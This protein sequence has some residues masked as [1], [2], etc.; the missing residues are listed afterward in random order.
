MSAP[1]TLDA[2]HPLGWTLLLAVCQTTLLALG[3]RAWLVSS[4]RPSGR[5]HAVGYTA[6]LASLVLAAGTYAGLKLAP[7]LS[8]ADQLSSVLHRVAGPPQLLLAGG[9]AVREPISGGGGSPAPG[10]RFDAPAA[11][12]RVARR[13]SAPMDPLAALRGAAALALP[14][15][16]SAW[17]LG[18]V[19]LLLRLA[20]GVWSVRRLR[21]RARPLPVDHAPSAGQLSERLGLVG[22]EWLESAEIDAPAAVGWRRPA[23]MLPAGL[24]ESMAPELLEPLLAHE[25]AHVRRH[26]ARKALLQGVADALLFFC[27]GA[28]WLS[29]QV[30][31]AREE[32]CDDAAVA[33]CG[34][35]ERCARAL[36]ALVGVQRSVPIL[37]A[38]G[39][40]APSLA[41]RI[42]RLLKGEDEMPRRTFVQATS[43]VVGVVASAAAVLVVGATALAA[44]PSAPAAPAPGVPRVPS[45]YSR[46]PGAPLAI[47]R[48][49]P[50]DGFVFRTVRVRNVS[51][52]RISAVRFVAVME[53]RT[54]AAHR[55]A[56]S[57]RTRLP[58]TWRP[59]RPRNCSP[60]C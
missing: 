38:I 10:G 35:R 50:G 17:A 7:G 6:L 14:V 47:T 3:V 19:F 2:L 15:A 22:V 8:F 44:R 59:E 54:S 29:A 18:A 20:G 43:V 1:V 23:V 28:R 58:R 32:N 5:R 27:P 57:K 12:E 42:R 55:C 60:R 30:R 52:Q 33:A 49:V 16:A 36:A 26:D 53:D 4:A 21:Q 25:L 9:E 56:S 46:Q 11:R 34:H 31:L 41:A 24:H 45:A 48:V 39:P 37:G 40:G 51:E 13:R